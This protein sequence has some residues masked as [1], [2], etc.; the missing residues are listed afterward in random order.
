MRKVLPLF[1]VVAGCATT[2]TSPAP[3]PCTDDDAPKCL[4]FMKLVSELNQPDG[5]VAQGL[6]RHCLNGSLESCQRLATLRRDR[7]LEKLCKEGLAE[8][9]PLPPEK[10]SDAVLEDQCVKH[11]VGACQQLL[12]RLTPEKLQA[13]RVEVLEAGCS[14]G[15]AGFCLALAHAVTPTAPE[16]AKSLTWHA[17]LAGLEPACLESDQNEARCAKGST[18]ACKAFVP[19]EED[20]GPAR[21]KKVALLE[22]ACRAGAAVVCS[23]LLREL[24]ADALLDAACGK[25]ETCAAVM[26][27]VTAPKACASENELRREE[28][29]SWLLGG[30]LGYFD[31]GESTGLTEARQQARGWA[32]RRCAKAPNDAEACALWSSVLQQ[33][34][35]SI[36]ATRVS[37]RIDTNCEDHTNL[38]ALDV[39]QGAK[40]TRDD[41]ARASLWLVNV[42]YRSETPDTADQTIAREVMTRACELGELSACISATSHNV[43]P[44]VLERLKFMEKAC[45]LGDAST[46]ADLK[47]MTAKQKACAAGHCSSWAY[48]F[49]H[50]VAIDL[51][52]KTCAAGEKDD[53]RT[54]H[55]LTARTP[56]RLIRLC[57]E[58]GTP[59]CQKQEQAAL[60]APYKACLAGKDRECGK[61]VEVIDFVRR[62]SFEDAEV[63]TWAVRACNSKD[64]NAC[65]GVA[66]AKRDLGSAEVAC[67]L[68]HAEG[69]GLLAEMLWNDRDTSARGSPAE[70][71]K[72]K[73]A[74][75]AALKGCQLDSYE[76][77]K[78]AADMVESGIGGP[79]D[80]L[81]ASRLREKSRSLREKSWGF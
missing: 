1:L 9:C 61:L 7:S 44:N 57:V 52:E 25:A 10:L 68:N 41:C 62:Q 17:C 79:Q 15:R 27:A 60:S 67:G 24:P 50:E 58:K 39:C 40:P 23:A 45:K 32:E 35:R 37:C 73:R 51:V 64:A 6:E 72:A 75:E 14:D 3:L 30:R 22:R 20:Q 66:S 11:E 19:T 77:C 63:M 48:E 12:R 56:S 13:T 78:L 43:T 34:G 69:C 59:F 31:E 81:E 74:R 54:W 49:D 80:A 28:G 4:S 76:G 26:S 53:C 65:Y 18:A 5:V 16:R 42:Q 8:A 70:L 33:T 36:E 21:A 47:L 29:C 38:A 2:Q 55:A 46:C 71:E